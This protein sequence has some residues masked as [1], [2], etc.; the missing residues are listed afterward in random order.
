[1]EK[2]EDPV[3]S[4]VEGALEFL[5]TVCSPSDYNQP[6][7]SIYNQPCFTKNIT[8]S[9]NWKIGT[10]NEL[11][12]ND[13]SGVLVWNVCNGVADIQRYI[14]VDFVSN[15]VTRIVN[16]SS[17]WF[18]PDR[19][20]T[21]VASAGEYVYIPITDSV[22]ISPDL[23]DQFS[24]CRSYA[25]RLSLISDDVPIGNTALTG[26]FAMGTISDQ[27]DLIIYN[28]RWFTETDLVQQ[29]ITG[30]DGIK[31]VKVDQGIVS[32]LGPD[33]NPAF[34]APDR[35]TT[36][37]MGHSDR[38]VVYSPPSTILTA[39]TVPNGTTTKMD[40]FET[41]QGAF[42]TPYNFTVGVG[43]AGVNGFGI[44]APL[45]RI[46]QLPLRGRVSID[47]SI[48]QTDMF[49][50]Y[51]TTGTNYG[52][53]IVNI[54]L[55]GAHVYV[56]MDTNGVIS[57]SLGPMTSTT[58]YAGT[59]AAG[60][61]A[62]TFVNGNPKVPGSIHIPSDPES[63]E[64]NGLYIGTI[65]QYVGQISLN[66]A[67]TGG[68]M[69]LIVNNLPGFTSTV[70]AEDIYDS[71]KLGPT[72]IMR[73]DGLTAGQTLKLDGCI[74]A[75]CVPEGNL[76]PFVVP[77]AQL[78][79]EYMQL[80]VYPWI[81]KLFNGVSE[82]KRNW[83]GTEYQEFLED[84]IRHLR[85]RGIQ[86]LEQNAVAQGEA[87]GLF[88]SLGGVLGGAYGGPLGG[89]LGT[90]AGGLGDKLLGGLLGGGKAAGEFGYS[91]GQFG[92]A[93]GDYARKEER[94]DEERRRGARS[95]WSDQL[96]QHGKRRKY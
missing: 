80:N 39:L 16:T 67:V 22:D 91:G 14:E 88:E 86:G 89:A 65:V 63:G 47:V 7:P 31:G 61:V 6:P 84:Y 58:L 3:V 11:G 43:I 32:L 64:T 59:F 50:E 55:M 48:D 36:L 5:Q 17:L 77:S 20:W 25:G 51:S 24:V 27:R 21:F 2:A 53:S 54:Y 26:R 9:G 10:I 71:G 94:Y 46:G 1:M 68:N 73:W 60:T 62:Q 34:S 85:E 28:D 18:T 93:A 95:N 12:Y 38:E 19:V 72:R 57:Y 81:S 79:P 29:S 23:G 15:N 52:A 44:F 82:F 87:A 74:L 37:Y 76:A 4:K 90:V 92:L 70:V 35:N 56:K 78:N 49:I 33:L 45:V 13:S 40:A 8:V 83:R 75:Q 41:A 66:T 42:I 96:M 69:A 30:K